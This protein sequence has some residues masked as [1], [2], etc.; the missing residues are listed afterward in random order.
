M[1]APRLAPFRVGGPVT[2]TLRVG[3]GA[4]TDIR[5][6]H[7]ELAGRLITQK[8]QHRR[9]LEVDAQRRQGR[10]RRQRKERHDRQHEPAD[11]IHPATRPADGPRQLDVWPERARRRFQR[12]CKLHR[13][14]NFFDSVE[15]RGQP[16]R[17]TVRKQAERAVTLGAIIPCDSAS[18]RLHPRVRSVAM[19]AASPPPVKRTLAQRC[20]LPPAGGNVLLVGGASMQA[21][22]HRPWAHTAASVVGSSFSMREGVGVSPTMAGA[23]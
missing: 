8:H 20:R 13:E 18:L 1:R 11:R 14:R 19:Q 4:E 23:P 15:R 21:N 10:S 17:Q 12:R 7:R 9:A 5:G 2:G 6:E 3:A 16:A 22:L